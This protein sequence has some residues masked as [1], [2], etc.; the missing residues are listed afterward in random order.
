MIHVKDLKW[1][2][3]RTNPKFVTGTI[4]SLFG[5][6]GGSEWQCEG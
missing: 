5:R 3:A 4:V 2:F 1:D 6:R